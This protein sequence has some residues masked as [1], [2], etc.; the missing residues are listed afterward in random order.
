MEQ[1]VAIYKLLHIEV[2]MM[3]GFKTYDYDKIVLI[4]DDE[5]LHLLEQLTHIK[6]VITP[7]DLNQS[8]YAYPIFKQDGIESFNNRFISS[9]TLKDRSG[10]IK[11]RR[12][13]VG[14]IL[15]A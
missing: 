13:I 12:K 5:D 6:A 9:L 8:S 14:V 15:A 10:V 4:R 1:M 2:L 7:L 11:M 3:E